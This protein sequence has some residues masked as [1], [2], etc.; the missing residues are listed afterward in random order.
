MIVLDAALLNDRSTA[1]TRKAQVAV[2]WT[3]ATSRK[4]PHGSANLMARSGVAGVIPN[5]NLIGARSIPSVLY[6]SEVD[7]AGPKLTPDA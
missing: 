2:P 7:L 6:Y 1:V 5:S 3:K 4:E